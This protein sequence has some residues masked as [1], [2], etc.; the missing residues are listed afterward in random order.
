MGL[1]NYKHPAYDLD[2]AIE[3]LNALREEYKGVPKG[4]RCLVSHLQ[5]TFRL[6]RAIVV[7]E[8]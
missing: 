7:N 5:L 1:N 4:E 2:K 3:E 8:E 6:K